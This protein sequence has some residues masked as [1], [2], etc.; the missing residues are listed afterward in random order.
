MTTQFNGRS[1]VN[2]GVRTFGTT[3]EGGFA[4]REQTAGNLMV[5]RTV[6]RARRENRAI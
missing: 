2:E 1:F 3:F 6:R 5:R 4:R